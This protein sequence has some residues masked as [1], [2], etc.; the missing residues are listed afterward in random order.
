[1][2][3][4]CKAAYDRRRYADRST[5]T[6]RQ[7]RA[8]NARRR[9]ALH[10]RILDLLRIN[11]CV[12]CGEKD[13]LVLQFDHVRGKKCQDISKC[14]QYLWSFARLDSEL[15]KCD[16]RCANCHMR[17]TAKTQKW[18]KYLLIHRKH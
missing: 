13:P 14:T 8:S 1:M 10:Q 11:P 4:I 15:A 12:D 9:L 17:R 18:A 16:V 7:I 3:R 6:E 2:C 5:G